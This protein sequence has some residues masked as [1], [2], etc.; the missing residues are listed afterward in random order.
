MYLQVHIPRSKM[1]Y[2]KKDFDPRISIK[3]KIENQK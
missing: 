2:D 3:C 1:M